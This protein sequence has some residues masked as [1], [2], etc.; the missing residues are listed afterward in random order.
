MYGLS[1]V[2]AAVLRSSSSRAR[3]S[4]AVMP[5]IVRLRSVLIASRRIVDACSAFHA[6]TGII[7]LSS[8]CPA[9]Q[10]TATVRSQPM[11]WKQTWFTIS[12]TDGFTFPGMIDDPGCTAGSTISERPARGPMLSRRRSLA[13]LPTSTASRRIALEYASTSPMLCVTRKRLTAGLSVKPV[14]R[15]RFSTTRRR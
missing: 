9:S 14:Y 11:T 5:S 3:A 7:T 10:A 2:A 15:A 8:S 1:A 13:T 6:M 12:G 4:S